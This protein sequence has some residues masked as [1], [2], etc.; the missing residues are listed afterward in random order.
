[1]SFPGF[2]KKVVCT[3]YNSFFRILA[4]ISGAIFVDGFFKQ[5]SNA[6]FSALFHVKINLKEQVTFTKLKKQTAHEI[7]WFT[8][9]VVCTT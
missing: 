9:K 7:S 3:T 2:A 5:I 1:M 4:L 8:K 6:S